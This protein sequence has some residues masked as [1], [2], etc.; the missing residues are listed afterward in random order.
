MILRILE[1]QKKCGIMTGYRFNKK[2]ITL[3][4]KIIY[5]T[6]NINLIIN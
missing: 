1:G 5:K 4:A 3:P 2:K 6:S